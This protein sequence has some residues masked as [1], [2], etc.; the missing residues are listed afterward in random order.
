[1]SYNDQQ[2]RDLERRL[3]TSINRASSK[4][5]RFPF[6]AFMITLIALAS[7]VLVAFRYMTTV[8]NRFDKLENSVGLISITQTQNQQSQQ[9]VNN[10][11]FESLNSRLT[12][13]EGLQE[14]I[15]TTSKSA[16]EQMNFVF[17]TVAAF[18]GLFAIFFAFRQIA[19]DTTREKHDEEMRGLVTSFRDNINVINSLIVTL[20]E[21]YRYRTEIETRMRQIDAQLLEVE[22]FKERTEQT[23]QEKVALINTEAFTLFCDH[24]DRQKFKTEENKGLLENFYININTLEQ[25]EDISELLNPFCYFLRALHFFNI[26]QYEPA[27]FDLEKANR[28]GFREIAAPSHSMYGDTLESEINSQLNRMLEDSSYHLGIIYYNLGQYKKAR[29]RFNEAYRKNSLDFRSRSYIPE[30]M[31]FETGIPLARVIAEFDT[32]EKELRD[33]SLEKRR[34]MDWPAAMASLKMRKGNCYLPKIIP[35]NRSL[36]FQAHREAYHNEEDPDK[37]TTIYKEAYE[38]AQK[39]EA[40]ST[41]T[42]IFVRFSLAQAL[43]HVSRSDWAGLTPTELFEQVFYDVRRQIV[44]KTE[45]ILLSLLNYVLAIC[46]S[47]ANISG[48]NPRAYLAQAREHLQKVPTSV[49]IFSPINKIN[50]SREDILQEMDLF[51]KGLN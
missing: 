11:S 12:S 47:R 31:F 30:L 23:L 14:A 8:N 18:F 24:V 15:A 34:S 50:L 48:E 29:E 10:P 25:T 41:L 32:V 4:A 20:E 16:L 3:N 1:M 13:L 43:E 5:N 7:L 22:R 36:G 9:T 42:E 2:L 35:I 51:E 49:L 39:I 6:F 37:A 19:T 40:K 46:V 28:M 17:A 33:L 38:E 45:P 26:T 21:N 27:S 44:H